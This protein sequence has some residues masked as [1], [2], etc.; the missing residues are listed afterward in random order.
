MPEGYEAM[1]IDTASDV[2]LPAD[3]RLQMDE[4]LAPEV[5]E[6]KELA[7]GSEV[8]VWGHEEV[9][10]DDEGLVKAVEEGVAWA[11]AIAGWEDEEEDN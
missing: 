10:G 9:V 1:V 11:N 2:V 5:K 7:K 3:E 4:G 8:I 6:I